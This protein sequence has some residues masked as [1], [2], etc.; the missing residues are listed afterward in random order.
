MFFAPTLL[1]LTCLAPPPAGDWPGLLGPNRDGRAELPLPDRWP[2]ELPVAW[3]VEVGGGYAGPV[4]AAGRA[5]Q[6][7]RRGGEEVLVCLDAATGAAVWQRAWPVAFA[8]S[9][10][11]ER[12]GPGPKATPA[13]GGGRI[14][15]HSITGA[16]RAWDA[17]TGELTWERNAADRFPPGRPNWGATASPLYLSD[18]PG[19]G[20]RVYL[21]VGTDDAG[22]LTAFDAATGET[23]W[24]LPGA[25]AS[26]S[27]PIAAAFGGVRQ[28]VDW[29]HE[30]V[31]GADEATGAKLWSFP[32]AHV[33]GD[34][35]MPTPVGWNGLVI[36]G[37][38]NRGVRALRPVEPD[39]A[40]GGWG[41]REVWRQD[42]VDA[43]MSTPG[44]CPGPDGGGLLYGFTSYRAGQLFCLD[45]ATGEIL[46]R[47]AGRAG[48]NAALLCV[49]GRTGEPGAVLALLDSGVMRVLSAA[50]RETAAIAEVRLAGGDAWAPVA[51]V[52]GGLLVKAGDTLRRLV[53]PAPAGE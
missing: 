42:A 29:D 23:V 52:P 10:G 38:E 27:S 5:Y 6:H 49:P 32:L 41:V 11:G 39:D 15:T 45:A 50:G 53:W 21:H 1:A 12:H 31:V 13:V 44:I 37:A 43:N 35:N 34:Q 22:A 8:A 47:G 51:P 33:G 2:E 14:Y 46:W 26:Y 16:L 20:D 7:A 17:A 30:A 19:D 36:V 48:A 4:V 18:L 28:V 40:G 9:P 3:S 24:E 25:G